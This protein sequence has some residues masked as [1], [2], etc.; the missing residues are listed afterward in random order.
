MTTLKRGSLAY[1]IYNAWAHHF[2]E[3]VLI[4]GGIRGFWKRVYVLASEYYL[5]KDV[6]QQHKAVKA[7][8]RAFV[9][10]VEREYY[11]FHFNRGFSLLDLAAWIDEFA[12]FPDV[13]EYLQAYVIWLQEES[14]R[15]RPKKRERGRGLGDLVRDRQNI[16][17]SEVVA[18]TNEQMKKLVDV[19]VAQ[20]QKT[21]AE[22]ESAWVGQAYVDYAKLVDVLE[23]MRSWGNKETVC[24]EGDWA[25]R[26]ALRSLWA[27]VKGNQELVQRLWEECYESLGLCAQ[28]H[29]SR[30]ANV[31]V[32]FEEGVAAPVNKKELFQNKISLLSVKEMGEAE[33]RVEVEELFR[34]YE[35]PSV[36]HEA[37]L[38]AVF[39]T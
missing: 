33:K 27:K 32:G 13:A 8:K 21:L 2:H 10:Y 5:E 36:E 12:F 38:D 1:D 4:R 19:H 14:E 17:T 31:L 23:D 34:E 16:H 28:G 30:L 25:Y 15:I 18:Q 9:T 7:A 22:I 29:L 24:E 11:K 35:I 20:K 39:T 26:K 3:E 6:V 37:W